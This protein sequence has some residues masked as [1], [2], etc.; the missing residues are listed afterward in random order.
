MLLNSLKIIHVYVTIMGALLTGCILHY[1]NTMILGSLSLS[2]IC[3]SFVV[4]KLQSV[5]VVA[6]S[7]QSAIKWLLQCIVLGVSVLIITLLMNLLIKKYLGIDADQ[8]IVNFVMA[9]LGLKNPVV[10]RDFDVLLYSCQPAFQ[11]MDASHWPR[12]TA[13]LLLPSY[14]LVMVVAMILL[15][16]TVLRKCWKSCESSTTVDAQVPHCPQVLA[17]HPEFVYHVLLSVF[18]AIMALSILRFKYLWLP[19][20]T[21]LTGAGISHS[22]MWKA[23]GNKLKT[24]IITTQTVQWCIAFGLILSVIVQ[25]LPAIQEELED[26]Q[27][28]YDPDIMEILQW[29]QDNAHP[30]ASFAGSMQ[31]MAS[32]K[33]CTGRHICNHPH[34]EHSWLRERTHQ[35][36]QIY[37]RRS[38]AEVHQILKEMDADFVIV[39]EGQCYTEADVGC[40]LRD[41]VDIVNGDWVKGGRDNVNGRFCHDVQNKRTHGR[42]F[43]LKFQNN[44]FRLYKVIM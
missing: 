19:H 31:L 8:H 2:F 12:L 18:L 37:G 23:I 28:F 20:A 35:V 6:M 41:I 17:A 26:L 33:L 29:I 27:E 21:I 7:S 43:L 24:S 1:G 32:V 14:V 36:C 11:A 25:H 34:Y 44:S 42:F 39:E 22:T 13:T 5:V 30:A 38:A 10:Q 4:I 3:A 9:K 15:A 16:V 40:R